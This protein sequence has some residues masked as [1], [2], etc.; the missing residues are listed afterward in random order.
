MNL[1]NNPILITAPIPVQSETIEGD[2]LRKKRLKVFRCDD[3]Q[4]T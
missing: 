2:P 3:N 1:E 4:I